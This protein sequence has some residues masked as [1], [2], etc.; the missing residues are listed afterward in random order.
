MKPKV[1]IETS[2]I[3]YLTARPSNNLIVAAYQQITHYW[4]ENRRPAFSLYISQFVLQEAGAG[5]EKAAKKRLSK[6]KLI[7][8]LELNETI[9]SLAELLIAEKVI[10]EKAKEDALHIATTAYHGID[11]LL[12]W[13]YKHIA[14]AEMRNNIVDVIQSQEYECPV[15]CTP[16]E[17]MGE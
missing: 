4:W 10:P 12:T 7:P 16:E 15:L 2:V 11:Y 1:Y 14:N 13:N 17:L 6:L 5:N 8:I 9:F 3:S